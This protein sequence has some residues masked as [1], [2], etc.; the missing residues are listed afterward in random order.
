MEGLDMKGKH[1]SETQIINITMA[2][3]ALARAG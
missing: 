1:Y 2:H 3:E